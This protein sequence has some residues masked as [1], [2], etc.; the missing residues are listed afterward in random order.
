MRVDLVA[1][2]ILNPDW[3]GPEEW[4]RDSNASDGELLV[5]FAGREC[6]QSFSNPAGRTNEGYIKNIIKQQHFS[7][8]E[9]CS[10]T[11]RLTGVSRS[12]GRELIR[13]RHLSFSELS[14]RYVDVSNSKWVVPPLLKED[15]KAC[16]SLDW[17]VRRAKEAYSFVIDDMDD[18]F[19]RKRQREAARAVMPNCIETKIV[20]TGNLRSWREVLY[21]RGGEGADLEMR[22]FA[23]TLYVILASEYPAVFFDFESY[24]AEDGFMALRKI[25][26]I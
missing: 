22:E 25:D 5:E 18:N 14:Q 11:F 10:V 20:V 9:H 6:Y 21:K 15:G 19:P 3:I 17:G 7:V 4:I 16:E 12:F 23:V 2:T 13:H 24:M 26:G 8:L 1:K